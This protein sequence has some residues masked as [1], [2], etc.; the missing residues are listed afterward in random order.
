MKKNVNYYFDEDD[1]VPIKR[2][3]KAESPKKALPEKEEAIRFTPRKNT[4]SS[5]KKA[6][7]KKPQAVKKELEV[8]SS[9]KDVE[10]DRIQIAEIPYN[11][12]YGNPATVISPKTV[13]SEEKDTFPH[14][15]KKRRTIFLR[16]KDR[17]EEKLLW[18]WLRYIHRPSSYRFSILYSLRQRSSHKLRGITA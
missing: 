17:E 10:G 3:K 13:S 15:C 11:R 14:T 16:R 4:V 18:S 5:I 2:R 8:K 9:E 1:A 7:E 12:E 6:D